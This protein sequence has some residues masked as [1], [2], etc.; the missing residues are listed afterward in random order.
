PPRY[1]PCP[2]R[3]TRDRFSGRQMP[4]KA[5]KKP[6]RKP[7]GA[8]KSAALEVHKFGGASL[9]DANAYRHAVD[10]IMDRD[11]PCVVVVAAP[12][13]VTDVLLGLAVRAAAGE[14]EG[15]VRDTEALRLRYQGIARA[16]T[17]SDKAAAGVAK[18]IDES[19][20]ELARLL[21]SLVVLK[22]LTARTSDFIA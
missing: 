15:L 21:A 11:A 8:K 13:G 19:L 5:P 14:Q 7:S 18:E 3:T 9:A 2:P 16:A 6:S 10:I 20:D 1:R 12:A 22:E 17:G 4:K